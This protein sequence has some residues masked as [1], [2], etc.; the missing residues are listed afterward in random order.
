MRPLCGA[1][2]VGSHAAGYRGVGV[3]SCNWRQSGC[4][5]AAAAAAAAAASTAATATAAAVSVRT[6]RHLGVN[7]E[8]CRVLQLQHL[9]ARQRHAAGHGGRGY[10][11][12]GAVLLLQ[13]LAE[14]LPTRKGAGA[15]RGASGRQSLRTGPTH[16]CQ[17]SCWRR[18]CQRGAGRRGGEEAPADRHKLESERGR[19]R[20]QQRTRTQGP[21][22][23][24]RKWRLARALVPHSQSS[25]RAAACRHA[26]S[27]PCAAGP[28]SRSGSR[29]P[30]RCCSRAAP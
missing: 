13:P 9:P 24:G 11:H 12:A 4:A 6:C 3:C 17:A 5:H 1:A 19:S 21:P 8:L 28:G 22:P 16:A 20:P 2:T 25:S 14:D 7:R 27:H 30:A 26:R 10:D 23:G 29:R 15:G 18:T